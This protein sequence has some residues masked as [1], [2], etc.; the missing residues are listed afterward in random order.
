[1]DTGAAIIVLVILAVIVLP[2]I[3]HY[4]YKKMKD[5]RFHKDYLN[6]AERD[7]LVF[8]KKELWNN[9]YAIGIDNNSGK[10]L[11]ANKKAGKTEA[12]L[13]DLSEVE[14]CRIANINR[15]FKNQNG[16][17]NISDRLE[18][19]FSFRNSTIPEKVLEFYDSTKF[20]PTADDVAFIENWLQTV[21]SNIKSSRN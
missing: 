21:N 4:L 11:Y 7:N 9:C 2:I 5:V 17:S 18:L 10:L 16:N 20:M 6:L 8:S 1:M 19:I 12:T 13:I 15:T 3:F 14:K